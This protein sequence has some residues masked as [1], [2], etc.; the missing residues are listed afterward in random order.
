VDVDLV[1]VDREA[2]VARQVAAPPYLAGLAREHDDAALVAHGED[3]VARDSYGGVDVREPLEL[4]APARRADL[5][6]PEQVAGPECD[7][8]DLAG[9]ESGSTVSPTA[10]GAVPRSESRGTGS[11]APTVPARRR[12]ERPQAAIHRA[13][14]HAAA[15]HGGVASTSP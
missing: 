14:D 10:R 13:Y 12:V 11:S 4:G 15:A 7:G 3:V 9:I 6:L 5:R 1:V 8:H 2:A